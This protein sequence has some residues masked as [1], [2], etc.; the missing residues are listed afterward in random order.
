[1]A[2]PVDRPTAGGLLHHLL[3]LTTDK[4]RGGHSLLPT[5]A[6]TDSFYFQKWDSLRCPDFP[7]APPWM[8]ATE[9]G[10]CFRGAKLMIFA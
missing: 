4:G 3:T 1:M 8:P 5:P 10:Q 7:L 2:Q 9:P 6:V